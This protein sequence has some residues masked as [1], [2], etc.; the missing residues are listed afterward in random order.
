MDPIESHRTGVQLLESAA[1]VELAG[2]DR[3][4]EGFEEWPVV[5]VEGAVDEDRVFV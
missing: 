5:R 1:R 4:Y 2:Q 3:E